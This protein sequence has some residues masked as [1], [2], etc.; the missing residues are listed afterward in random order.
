MQIL[1]NELLLLPIYFCEQTHIRT[2]AVSDTPLIFH[3]DVEK[4]SVL[5]LHTQA[6]SAFLFHL[7]IN[8][9]EHPVV[10]LRE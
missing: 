1:Q 5:L 6:P 8:F 4:T 3:N 2:L 7:Q 9:E 10:F